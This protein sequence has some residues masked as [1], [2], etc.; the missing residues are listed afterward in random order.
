MTDHTHSSGDIHLEKVFEEHIVSC[1]TTQ[2]G[3]V[4]RTCASDYDVARAL[5]PELL[6]RFLK[7][8]QA[9][10]W[11]VLEDH[12][13]DQAEAEVLKRLEK[14]L[15][16]SPTHVVQ[17]DGIKLVPN[18]R[19]ALFY[20]KPASNLNPDLMRANR[21][22]IL[23]VMRQV[24]YSAKNNNAIDLA[25]FVNGIPVATFEVK[26]LLTGQNFR[27]A[28]RQYRKDRS[29]AGEPLLTFKRGAI[30]HF[31]LDQDNVSMTTRLRNG[32]TWFLP[33]NRGRDRGAG[34]PDVEGENRVAYLYADLPGAKAILSREVLLDLIGRFVHL[35]RKKGKETLIFPRFQRLDAVRVI[36]ADAHNHG[37]GQNYL[38]QHS[39]GSG[40]S[41]TIA[42]TAHQIINLHDDADKPLFDTA[43]IV[44]DRIVL[45]R[46]LQ[47]SV[48][49][50]WRVVLNFVR[51]RPPRPELEM[52]MPQE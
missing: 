42:W 39:A 46:Q 3:Y 14:A 11:Q 18:I 22:N 34:N 44:T 4:E 7:S 16:E 10:A 29:P 48:T 45:D 33:F 9:E 21:A 47:D 17:R 50:L 28:E 26:N 30:V 12:Y 8:T 15:R 5:D 27:H 43:I 37:A 23:S 6:F 1:L 51:G 35:E 41:N 32:K 31:A 24:T 40:K 52:K 13:S 38:I 2:Q 20:F 49:K 25:T 19:F 36:L